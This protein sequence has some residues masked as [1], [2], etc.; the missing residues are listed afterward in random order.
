MNDIHRVR[1]DPLFVFGFS[2]FGPHP[3]QATPVS[4]LIKHFGLN[5]TSNVDDMNSLLAE[6]QNYAPADETRTAIR[7][8]IQE[9]EACLETS[10]SVLNNARIQR[11]ITSKVVESLRHQ[12]AEAER[13]KRVA[14]HSFEAAKKAVSDIEATISSYKALVH[15]I[16]SLPSDILCEI[17]ERCVFNHEYEYASNMRVAIRLS[18]VCRTWRLVAHSLRSL[19]RY[20]D[21]AS[22]DPSSTDIFKCFLDRST[23]YLNLHVEV[24]F[25]RGPGHPA[26]FSL[27]GFPF[28]RIETL[29]VGVQAYDLNVRLWPTVLHNLTRLKVYTSCSHGD[30]PPI[31]DGDLLRHYQNLKELELEHVE[32]AFNEAF[33]LRKLSRISLMENILSSFTPL[34]L[35]D[36]FERAP[37]LKS[38][39]HFSIDHVDTEVGSPT[40]CDF[41][42]LRDLIFLEVNYPSLGHLMAPFLKDSSLL[43]SIQHLS[44]H[45]IDD[46][47]I[48]GFGNL[49]A[50]CGEMM[51]LTTLTLEVG[52]WTDPSFADDP[53]SAD[54][55]E[56]RIR[57][58]RHFRSLERLEV[59]VGWRFDNGLTIDYAPYF[60]TRL[61]KVLSECD[62]HPLF[63]KLRI[64]RFCG[65]AQPGAPVGDIIKMIEARMMAATVSPEKL[66]PLESVTVE[67]C[68]SF[69]IDDYRQLEAAL[70][71]S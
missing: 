19:W 7:E 43:P 44:L 5:V 2:Y 3:E 17:F 53:A 14:I 51:S 50:Q 30:Y 24:D 68:E 29:I 52:S 45:F 62:A 40:H 16:R 66:V 65:E 9:R 61:C 35:R 22:W 41:Q 67:D 6:L 63:P 59:V 10:I 34:S 33:V 23:H 28:S 64:I 56:G 37:H 42:P 39:S 38:I 71:H 13:A 55:L 18:S 32:I 12:L 58:L 26:P 31:L 49:L 27:T 1:V 20:I 54:H 15:P 36:L 57:A 4:T 69:G 11:E 8:M 21:Y 46:H 47:D 70:G 48:D 60:T 25:E